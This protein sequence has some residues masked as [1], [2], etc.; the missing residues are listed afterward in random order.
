MNGY[1]LTRR[2]KL[3]PKAFPMTKVER[4]ERD[5]EQL[6]PEELVAFRKWFHGYDAA[7]W[8][9]QL[10]RDASSGKLDPLA[11]EALAEHN[12]QRTREL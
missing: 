2:G 11:N 1:L 10:R 8:D 9:Q 5:V 3:Y 12:A 4:I 6:S 7:L